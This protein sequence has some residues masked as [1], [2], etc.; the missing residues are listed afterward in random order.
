MKLRK[1]AA[2][3]VL[4]VALT[5][6]ANAENTIGNAG[7]V[8]DFN[9]DGTAE[10]RDW[11]EMHS[12]VVNYTMRDGKESN[13]GNQEVPA[14]INLIID[15]DYA[16]E[17][18]NRNEID[19]SSVSQYYLPTIGDTTAI[20]D[21]DPFGTCWAFA[22]ISTLESNLLHKRHGNSGVVNP[23]AFTLNMNNV[24]DEI[25]LSEL[26][27]AYMN[28]EPVSDGSQKG[29][30]L[31]P[32]DPEEANSHLSTGG[33]G[34]SS[35]VL[36]TGWTGP[37]AESQEPYYPLETTESGL[38]VYGVKDLQLDLASPSLAHVHE[39]IYL[40]GTSRYHI[41]TEK[42]KYI[43]DGFR[44]EAVD[45]VKQ[46]M[47]KHGALML[48]YQADT[49]SP[50]DKGNGEYMNYNEFCQFDSSETVR[51]NHMVTVVGWNDDYPRENFQ[52][53]SGQMPENNGAF[54]IKNSWGNYDTSVK[55]YGERFVEAYNNFGTTNEGKMLMMTFNYGI[56][57]DEGHGTGY[58][59]ISYEDHS[60]FTFS[61]IDGDDAADGYD[62]DHI[63][64]Y[65]FVNP[66][67]FY[68]ISLPTDNENTLIANVFTSE[69]D[70]SLAA[71]SVYAPENNT[72]ADI[73]IYRLTDSS[74]DPTEGELLAETS[75]FFDYRGFHTVKLDTPISLSQGD[76]F[77]VVE[78]IRTKKDGKTVSWLNIEQT[79]RP[80][81]QTVDNYNAEH[82]TVVA[83]PGETLIYVNNGKELV[84][85]DATEL[86]T[87][88]AA[89]IMAFGNAY[90]KAYTVTSDRAPL[91]TADATYQGV[92]Q[93]D[94]AALEAVLLLA[95]FSKYIIIAVIA[96]VLIIALIIFLIVRAVK[97]RKAKKAAKKQDPSDPAQ[98]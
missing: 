78:S 79:L 17:A 67:S 24:S 85:A 6:T 8:M 76:R 60:L 57:D 90:I 27:H 46:A 80:D 75:A 16:S 72:D 39:F 58:I 70:E 68:P 38:P 87:T 34:S 77:A 5:V 56:P 97:K 42:H 98:S 4:L 93:R 88:D 28:M 69:Q 82:G 61:A 9:G 43:Y 91:P 31:T 18:V 35:Q 96:A 63:Y 26:Y 50:G 64:Q 51:T 54:L 30:G 13:Y 32:A 15:R 71:V 36:F 86:N 19:L 62:Y 1:T 44:Q 55:R 29:E 25:D 94:S 52:T 14:S 21:Q 3:A 92:Y 59:W 7:I 84:W 95:R 66:V 53:G 2:A 22:A 41:D 40:D 73:R 37:L 23:D 10:A 33:F 83:N 49:S 47:I 81:L 48:M 20:K 74:T 45:L 12:W 65:D 11:D 89:R